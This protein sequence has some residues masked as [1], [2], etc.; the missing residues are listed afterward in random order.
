MNKW[1]NDVEQFL[2]FYGEHY[3][4]IHRSNFF[5]II[6]FKLLWSW[7]LLASIASYGRGRTVFLPI[8]YIFNLSPI[9][10]N[11]IFIPDGLYAILL[12]STSPMSYGKTISLSCKNRHSY[13]L[14]I[15]YLLMT[16]TARLFNSIIIM[17]FRIIYSVMHSNY[18]GSRKVMWNSNKNCSNIRIHWRL[19]NLFSACG[20]G[21]LMYV[22]RPNSRT[23]PACRCRTDVSPCPHSSCPVMIIQ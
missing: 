10:I 23:G 20:S 21:G 14:T 22:L 3:V 17:C 6:L 2:F 18:T 9:L 7:L 13:T 5:R 16:N 4:Q 11:P 1:V 15:Y 8:Y 12:K 19:I